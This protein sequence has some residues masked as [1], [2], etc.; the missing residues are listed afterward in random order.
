MLARPTG[1]TLTVPRSRRTPLAF[2]VV[3]SML[4]TG[5]DAP[6][7]G[8]MYLNRPIRE[9]ELLQAIA[10]VNR[11]GHGK[12][13][14]ISW[15]PTRRTTSRTRCAVSRTRFPSCTTTTGSYSIG[16]P[17]IVHSGPLRGHMF[18]KAIEIQDSSRS[19]GAECR[20]QN[21]SS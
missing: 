14:G 21:S 1:R 16:N 17:E 7:E 15:P 11:T 9:A 6:I 13:A 5:F 12:K 19:T 3:K 10:R 2:L 8:V 4:L 20:N 18:H